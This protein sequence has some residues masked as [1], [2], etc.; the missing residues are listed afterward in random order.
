VNHRHVNVS[1]GA[2]LDLMYT[3]YLLGTLYDTLL[4]NVLDLC[5]PITDE[6]IENYVAD[7]MKG[8]EFSNKDREEALADLKEWRDT[9][10]E[11][12]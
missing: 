9:C 2:L 1:V 4:S 12:D 5:Q 7:Y 3:E 8:D 11:E 10:V 6:D